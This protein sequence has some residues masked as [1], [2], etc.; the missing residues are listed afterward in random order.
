MQKM[1]TILSKALGFSWLM[2]SMVSCANQSA[3]HVKLKALVPDDAKIVYEDNVDSD[4]SMQL[5]FTTTRKYPDVAVPSETVQQ[6]L[7]PQW[8]H[9]SSSEVD[10]WTSFVEGKP[11]EDSFVHQH[12]MYFVS[13]DQLL[14]VAARYQSKCASEKCTNEQAPGSDTQVVYLLLNQGPRKNIDQMLAYNRLRC[15]S[16]K[17]V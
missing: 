7:G 1:L 10:K 11:G 9:C 8:K 4:G 2:L 5:S 6:K 17:P 13:G 12:L 14:T 16:R 3:E 15:E